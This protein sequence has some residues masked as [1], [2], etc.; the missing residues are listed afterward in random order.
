MKHQPFLLFFLLFGACSPQLSSS[1]PSTIQAGSVASCA[2]KMIFSATVSTTVAAQKISARQAIEFLAQDARFAA[3]AESRGI[4]ASH[5]VVFA[6]KALAVRLLLEQLKKQDSA[7]V[8]KEEIQSIRK[9][10]WLDFDRPEGA[11]VIHAVVLGDSLQALKIAEAI[12]AAT[13][14]VKTPSDFESKA[15]T[16]EH[17]DIEVRIENLPM[18]SKDGKSLEKDGG[19]FDS[20]FAEAAL[21]LK[22]SGE[23]SPIIK[24]SFGYHLIFLIEHSDAVHPSDEELAQIAREELLSR[25]WHQEERKQI[26]SLRAQQEI[27]IARNAEELTGGLQGAII[28]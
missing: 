28:P 10:R 6:K 24:T 22:T 8:T 26:A 2:G 3:E 15:K 1:G 18:M 17:G 23:I 11:R 16:V 12:S 21:A 19:S 13:I 20:T 9:D 25:R 5:Q 27:L 14:G 7:P 4:Q